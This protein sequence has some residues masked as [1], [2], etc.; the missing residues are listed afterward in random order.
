[1]KKIFPNRF[2]TLLLFAS[3]I[4]IPGCYKENNNDTQSQS[5][6]NAIVTSKDTCV[7][8]SSKGKVIGFNPLMNFLNF[9]T[10][11]FIKYDSTLGPGYLIEIDND[12]TKDTVICY[13]I[14]TDHF[15]YKPLQGNI[16]SLYLFNQQYQDSLKIKFNY[17]IITDKTEIKPFAVTDI[18]YARFSI[19][20]NYIKN[21]KEI[22]MSCV[23]HQ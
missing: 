8:P 20:F 16:A 23:S 5:S 7:N 15:Q 9:D 21:K 3:V 4:V 18:E 1:M 10:S 22:A 2:L 13:R 17:H 14:I 6:L 11:R 19:W 12:I